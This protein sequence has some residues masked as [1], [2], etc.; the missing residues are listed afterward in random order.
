MTVISSE[1]HS[2][3]LLLAAMVA[4]LVGPLVYFACLALAAEGMATPYHLGYTLAVGLPV[5][6][7]AVLLIGGPIVLWLRRR[8]RL[9]LFNVCLAGMLIGAATMVAAFARQS[10]MWL[11]LLTGLGLGLLAGIVFAVVA[12]IRRASRARS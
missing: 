8:R 7:A 10:D 2:R 6:G 4:S 9:T 1:Q 5:S 3:S 12:G 11:M